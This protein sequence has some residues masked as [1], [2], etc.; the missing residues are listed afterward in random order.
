MKRRSFSKKYAALKIEKLFDIKEFFFVFELVWPIA[1][2]IFN[3]A[4]RSA[5]KIYYRPEHTLSFSKN[6][7]EKK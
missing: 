6:I 1:K 3:R 5:H 7:D 4:A 2:N